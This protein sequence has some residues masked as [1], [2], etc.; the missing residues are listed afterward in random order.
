RTHRL[1][2][3]LSEPRVPRENVVEAFLEQ[4]ANGLPKTEQEQRRRSVGK[5]SLLHV[6][7]HRAPIVEI[8]RSSV[9]L[10]CIERSWSDAEDRAARRQHE[11]LLRAGESDVDA[12]LVHS[13]IDRKS[14]RLN[15]SHQI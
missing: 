6:A 15:S 13:E 8:P 1:S 2:R 3:G 11:S 7:D 12:P 4:H 9:R 14:T 10:G 5:E